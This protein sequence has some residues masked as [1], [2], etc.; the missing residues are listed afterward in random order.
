MAGFKSSV[1]IVLV[2]LL[3]ISNAIAQRTS[4]SLAVPKE[5]GKTV[6]ELLQKLA[7]A[8]QDTN[9]VNLLLAQ[10]HLYWQAKT[11]GNRLLDSSRIAAKEAL[12]ISNKLRYIQ[13]SNEANFMLARICVEKNDNKNAL[14]IASEVYG[15]ER[16]RILLT[17][18]EH[19]VFTR[20][21]RNQIDQAYP[22]LAQAIN[23][24]RSSGSKPWYYQCL[25]LLGK[26]YFLKGDITKGREAVL[27]IINSC[28]RDSDFENEG[29][30]WSELGNYIPFTDSSGKEIIHYHDMAVK[31]YL[32]AGNKQEAAYALRDKATANLKCNYL[33]SAEKDGLGVFSILRSIKKSPSMNTYLVMSDIYQI[34]GDF[35]KA[36]NYTLAVLNLPETLSDGKMATLNSELGIIYDQLNQ[37]EKALLYHKA[38]FEYCAS[39]NSY[40]LFF[41]K[42]RQIED[43]IKIGDAKKS[44]KQF[45][46]FTKKF[47][48]VDA[49]TKELIAAAYGDLYF[50]LSNHI[51]A[52]RY[53]REMITQDQAAQLESNK[54][55]G[56]H[57]SIQGSEALHKIG[58]F[59]L[60]QKQYA[61]ARQYLYG[62]LTGT[63]S[64][65]VE[66]RSNIEFSMFKADSALGNYVSAIRYFE[67]S[68]DTRDSMFNAVKS[69]QI[70]EL[71]IKYRT[72]LREKS[73]LEL[74]NK[75]TLQYEELK[76]GELE[77]TII[78]I[79][80]A[81]SFI[82]AGFA[83]NGYRN[84][85]RSN[86]NLTRQQVEI[87]DQN[88]KL[89]SLVADKDKL[90]TEKDWL[91][92]EVHHRVK[93]NLQI[94]MSLLSSQSSYLEN[95]AALEAIRE[96]QNRVQAIS[97]IHQKLYS[98]SGNIASI[99]MPAYVSDLT[100]HLAD[101]FDIRRR[102][103]KIEQLIENFNLDLAQAVPLGLILNEAITNAI[104]Y[105]FG[106]DGGD[107]IIGLQQ[108]GVDGL[109]LH[110]SDN[111]KGLP[112]NFDLEHAKSLGMEMMKALSKQLGGEFKMRN[113]S[114][115]H[116][117]IEFAAEPLLHPDF[118]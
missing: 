87:N 106:P 41:W 76:R 34:K 5:E 39:I 46:V 78:L 77:R 19:L 45:D 18:G 10:S 75:S 89:Q 4:G 71:D 54:T 1:L 32:R 28:H 52:E 43:Q 66:E 50:A 67:H 103:I 91:L 113:I 3:A 112:D 16:A 74:K 86:F 93:N 81:L 42:Y 56:F 109:I 24:S 94:V 9:K 22:I 2:C 114:G 15:E 12:N 33:D 88:N 82:I 58:R 79:G 117:S 96:S 92:K 38:V 23:V 63:Q 116:I 73:F 102:K 101:C 107:I 111:G 14:K 21:L 64:S 53:Y 65:S 100:G 69:R 84:K 13:G 83:Y 90:L 57:N 118:A 8:G 85:K 104:K 115:L 72:Q 108:V 26:F 59:Y 17:I 62:A 48:P 49:S 55:L 6:G 29:H 20:E 99:C 80:I 61:I 7:I 97:L 51:K 110:I 40:N 98:S 44:L 37:P 11:E 70:S 36:L 30:Y 95:A 68:N 31:C 35:P 105:A 47:Q 60:A 27:Q 25:L